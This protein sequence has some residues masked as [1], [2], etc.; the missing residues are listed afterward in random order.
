MKR[1]GFTNAEGEGSLEDPNSEGNI[2]PEDYYSEEENEK[3]KFKGQP[4]SS[5]IPIKTDK[6]SGLNLEKYYDTV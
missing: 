2:D 6:K 3:N 5:W 4:L 1:L